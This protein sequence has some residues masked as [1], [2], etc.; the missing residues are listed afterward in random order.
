MSK[1]INYL[2]IRVAIWIAV[3]LVFSACKEESGDEPQ[4][5]IQAVKVE[6]SEKYVDVAHRRTEEEVLL[7]AETDWEL[8]N[9]AESWVNISPD[10]GVKGTNISLTISIGENKE[11]KERDAEIIVKAKSGQAADTL[12]IRQ[13]GATPYVEIKWNDNATLTDFNPTSGKVEVHFNGRVPN[14]QAGVSSIVVPTDS[15]S[16]IRLVD[17]VSVNGNKVTLQTSEGDMTDVFMNK[18]FTLSTVPA[19]KAVRTRSGRINTTDDDGV[20]HPT[21]ITTSTID[22][23]RIVLYDV[24]QELKTRGDT[25]IYGEGEKEFI[26]KKLFDK[27]GE[28]IFAGLSWEK[29]NLEAALNGKFHFAFGLETV[30]VGNGLVVPKG[31]LLGFWYFLEGEINTAFILKMAAESAYTKDLPNKLLSKN[32]LPKDIQLWFNVSGVLLAV[33]VNADLHLDAKFVA[34]ASA[35]L[36]GGFEAGIKMQS[37]LTYTKDQPI[38]WIDE[39]P[40]CYYTPHKP[41]VSVKG[42]IG[43]EVTIYPRI[44]MFFYNFAGPTMSIK[45]YLGAKLE[46]GTNIG[47]DYAAWT[48]RLYAKMGIQLGL[49]LKFANI[50]TPPMDSPEFLFPKDGYDLYRSPE[51]IELVSPTDGNK[52]YKANEPIAVTFKVKDFMIAD[53]EAPSRAAVVKFEPSAGTVDKQ[54]GITNADGEVTVNWT[55]DKKDSKLVAKIT[56][57]EGEEIANAVFAPKIKT[58][59]QKINLVGRWSNRYAMQCSVDGN[60][61][62]HEVDFEDIFTLFED[63]RYIYV[64]NPTKVIWDYYDGWYDILMYG[65]CYGTYS[66]DEESH[67]LTLK[68]DK[69]SNLSTYVGNQESAK[70]SLDL[71]KEVDWVFGKNGDYEI[72]KVK[73]DIINIKHLRTFINGSNQWAMMTL[74]KISD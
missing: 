45:P 64:V 22:G 44:K 59:I 67:M 46:A 26:N 55:P 31:D 49:S 10:E 21:K 51:K 47:G 42:S 65:E 6:F 39:E 70:A 37:G 30:I 2:S 18:E 28:T 74:K 23:Q 34:K 9:A 25:I 60:A 54:Y 73:E 14:F 52:E 15:F 62:S 57:S 72:V 13:S 35:E 38:K 66:Y 24:E 5:E 41:E 27:D 11:E 17:A 50:E 12:F 16:Y 69:V 68:V 4:P 8:L 19:S 20:I 53:K 61:V 3:I 36:K 7:N 40:K 48:S 56:D 1:Y 63:G 58:N 33:N 43:G 29:C 71:P 32:I